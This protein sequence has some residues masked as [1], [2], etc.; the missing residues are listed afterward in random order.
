MLSALTGQ[1]MSS[2]TD[3]VSVLDRQYCQ[4]PFDSLGCHPFYMR[5]I[6]RKLM[7]F[8]KKIASDSKGKNIVISVRGHYP[9]PLVKGQIPSEGKLPSTKKTFAFVIIRQIPSVGLIILSFKRYCPFDQGGNACLQKQQC[10]CPFNAIRCP[11]LF[12]VHLKMASSYVFSI[13]TNLSD[14]NFIALDKNK[15]NIPVI[16]LRYY[17]SLPVFLIQNTARWRQ[18][19]LLYQQY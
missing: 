2:L 1:R 14:E 4:K 17:K 19:T 15:K 18:G 11:Q 9:T 10:F 3:E 6:F 8:F 5:I 7:I 12:R 13:M 16:T